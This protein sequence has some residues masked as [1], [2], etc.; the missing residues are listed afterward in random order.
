MGTYLNPGG[1]LFKMARQSQIYV[2]KSGII[3]HLN[4]WV[5]TEN[6]YICVSRPRRFGKSMAA[7]MIAAYYDRTV[8]FE[9]MFRG[10][11]LASSE[12]FTRF[13]ARYDVLHINMQ[14]FLSKADDAGHMIR[15]LSERIVHELCAAY[16]DVQ[17]YDREDLSAVMSDIFAVTKTPFVIVIDEWDCIFREFQTRTTEQR[18]Y[19][20]FLREWLKDR[21]YIA[22]VYMTG[23]LPIRKYGTHSAL[24]MFD[25]YSMDNP[26]IL[27]EYVG[28]TEEEVQA[29]CT[30]YDMD[31]TEAKSWYDGYLFKGVGSI[32][33]PRS[34][35]AS[36][37]N[38]IYDTYWNK[39]E[40][41]EALKGYIDLNRDGL[42]DAIISLMSGDRHIVNV[43]TFSNDM[44]SLNSVDDVLTLMVHLGYLGYDFETKEVYVPNREIYAEFVNATST[45][46]WDIVAQAIRDSARLLENTLSEKADA[47]AKAIEKAHMETSHIQ[48]NDENALSYT[49]SLAYYS[50]RQ[51]YNIIRE[52]PTGNGYADITFLPRPAHAEKP[53]MVVELKWDQTASSAIDQIRDRKYTAS[54]SGFAG[55]LLLVG[56][57][58][59][60]STRAH[61]CEIER[62]TL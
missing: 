36:M 1:T 51:Y 17:M 16:P 9:D 58:Y 38:R 15:L 61:S 10:L 27:A 40:T 22:L 41:F 33:S 46:G 44:T 24:N 59:D 13:G 45:G 54:L 28:F 50:A 25:Q 18:D 49:I 5:E 57:N 32:Y 62:V 30:E 52:L 47:V 4:R 31:F 56:I 14:E 43:A 23:I 39:T 26:G 3:G 48:Y 2:D 21:A 20:D 11:K 37:Q 55:E 60:K 6:R 12:Q 8:D 35:V 34:V 53:A 7:N 29:L 19:L 42:R